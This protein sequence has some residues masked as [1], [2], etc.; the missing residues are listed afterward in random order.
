MPAG[1]PSI[2][3]R[4]AILS[5]DGGK[6]VGPGSTAFFLHANTS[7]TI[8]RDASVDDLAAVLDTGFLD[9]VERIDVLKGAKLAAF[10]P[11][12]HRL[13]RLGWIRV[14][15]ASF[16]GWTSLYGVPS[17]HSLILD[18]VARGALPAGI[19]A[20]SSLSVLDARAPGIEALPPDLGLCASLRFV[21]VRPS[22]RDGLRALTVTSRSPQLLLAHHGGE[23]RGNT[24]TLGEGSSDAAL[25]ALVAT[26]HLAQ[27][28][29]LE[30]G[31]RSAVTSL[32]PELVRQGTLRDL[33]VAAPSFSG[34]SG[35]YALT[36]LEALSISGKYAGA[37]PDG[38]SALRNLSRLFIDAKS[39]SS[40]PADL[41]SLAS[42]REVK[43]PRVKPLTDLAAAERE[44]QAQR[45]ARTF[46]ATLARF[47]AWLEAH[48]PDYLAALQ[49]GL[50]SEAIRALEG[51]LGSALPPAVHALYR[52]RNGVPSGAG[53][54]QFLRHFLPLDEA[55]A[56]WRLLVAMHRA[57][58]WGPGLPGA[59]SEH[60]FP[61]AGW[62]NGFQLAIDLRGTY[63]GKRGQVLVA[64]LKDEDRQLAAPDLGSW[65][66]AHVDALA[67]GRI[68]PLA[69][70]DWG[71]TPDLGLPG[72]PLRKSARK[73]P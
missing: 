21:H 16:D 56:R 64:W 72:Y 50:T 62:S 36:T 30:L 40:I 58:E 53:P 38:I 24:L 42:L 18:G 37:L 69:G 49:P 33:V 11:G 2:P 66:A 12:L 19:A 47:E 46:E 67:S 26:G 73:K 71:P 55:M 41:S 48:L 59:W 52:W 43:L 60:W 4:C 1:N 45:E 8:E 63:K 65:W 25:A 54:L 57:A 14:S 9:A 31:P 34:W 15:N 32:P 35:V 6:L 23:L 29:R 44:L 22:L 17:L 10:P 27:L 5:A 13:A 7:L 70:G 3:A 68:V 51:D 28:Q 20:L 61:I 39:I